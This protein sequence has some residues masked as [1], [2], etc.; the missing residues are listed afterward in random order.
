MKSLGDTQISKMVSP[1][2]D[3]TSSQSWAAGPIK[4]SVFQQERTKLD[5]LG[6]GV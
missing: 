5:I 2:N 4:L 3:R 6:Q 1:Y